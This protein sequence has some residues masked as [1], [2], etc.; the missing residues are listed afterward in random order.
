MKKLLLFAASL[1][2][3]SMNAQ[4]YFGSEFIGESGVNVPSNSTKLGGKLVVSGLIGADLTGNFP[5]TFKGGNADGIITKLSEIDGSIEWIKQFGGKSDEAVSDVTLDAAGNYYLTGYFMG[6]GDYALDADPGPGV[7]PLSVPSN[8]AN[9]DIFI[10]KLDPNGD[11]LW[12]KQIS[13]PSGAGN[14]DATTIKVDSMGNILVAG[15]YVYVDFDPGPGVQLYTA[16]GNSD[17]YVLKLDNDGNFIWVKTFKGTS[18]KKVM[19]MELDADDNIYLTGRFQGT[20][21]LN[22]DDSA[23]DI[24][25]TAG[26]LDTFLVKYTSSGDYVWGH[27]YGGTGYDTIEKI[28]VK[29]NK[30]YIGGGFSNTVD[31]DPTSGTNI[32]TSAGGQDA[33]MSAFNSDGTYITSYVIPSTTANGDVVKDIMID[34]DGNFILA[35]LFQ[36]MTIGTQNY[37][38]TAANSD[39]FY[40]KLNA[41]LQFK[42]IY[43]IQGPLL[44]SSPL[45]NSLQGSKLV[46]IGSTKGST[47]FDYTNGTNFESPSTAAYFIYF[48]KFDFET[49]TLAA[50]EQA[51]NS[52]ISVYP[53]PAVNEVNI[54]SDTAINSVSLFNMEGR[55]VYNMNGSNL[56]T[57]NVAMISGGTYIL[58]TK[59][60]KGNTQQTKLIKK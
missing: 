22:A 18:N 54:K 20:M 53:N 17:A 16:T 2:F 25:T 50:N 24:R 32:Y 58:Q 35:G 5:I 23:T 15:S 59:D 3:M 42:A 27:S 44:Q 36:N 57:L 26:G 40:L 60:A 37:V 19:D 38:A 1:T 56:K 34:D 39:I 29:N 46:G 33:Y 47:A 45:I 9:R 21:D 30:V 51:V 4:N 10:I 28:T 6:S 11:F 48:T 55:K 41:A 14:D 31:L 12:A 13:S 52:K 49:S 43:L 7:Y 8:L